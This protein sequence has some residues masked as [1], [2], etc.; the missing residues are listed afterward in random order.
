MFEGK[1]KRN[2]NL[3]LKEYYSLKV[4]TCNHMFTEDFK[5]YSE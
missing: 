3:G 5:N 2:T 1:K 4:V